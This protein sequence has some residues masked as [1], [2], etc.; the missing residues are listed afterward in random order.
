MS[1]TNTLAGAAVGGVVGCAAWIGVAYVTG[2]ELGILAILVGT[3]CGIG[4]AIGA[5]GMAGTRGGLI[6]AAVTI[7]SIV[8]ARYFI[9]Q[10]SINQ[11]VSQA[12]AE[13][14]QDIPGQEDGEFW[15]AFMADQ[16]IRQREEAGDFV[17]WPAWDE[18]A[19]ESLAAQYPHEVWSNASAQWRSMNGAERSEFCTA[20]TQLIMNDNAEG[21]DEFRGVMGIIGILVSN[22]HPMALIIMGIAVCTAFKVA[23]NSRPKMPENDLET[24]TASSIP[25]T[26]MGLAGMPT[27]AGIGPGLAGRDASAASPALGSAPGAVQSPP[28]ES[29][30]LPPWLRDK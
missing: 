14:G 9:V 30:Y 28:A 27:G 16:I 21:I 8:A 22:L 11:M 19:E 2:Y 5:K 12:M 15:T 4:A 23:R 7:L 26:A 18:D 3:A 13:N 6:A 10:I 29:T 25:Q 20:G 24:D 1:A 17:E